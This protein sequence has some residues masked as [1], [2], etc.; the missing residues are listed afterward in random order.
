MDADEYERALQLQPYA[1]VHVGFTESAPSADLL[2]AVK[3]SG[4]AV[5]STV[6]VVDMTLLV[7]QTERM[8]DPWF[9]MLVP[10]NQR[11]TAADAELTNEMLTTVFDDNLPGWVPR[12]LIRLLVPFMSGAQMS[13][14]LASSMSAAKSMY[15]AGIPLVMG[16]D[17]GN[18]P[19]FTSLFHGV[20]SIREMELLEQAGIPR[21]A[22]L[23]AATTR[24]AALLGKSNEI[25]ALMAGMKAD[26]IISNR[27]PT[28]EGMTALRDLAY[29][30]KDGEIRTP[31]EWM[32]EPARRGE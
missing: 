10:R 19:V 4:A 21:E 17:M 30:M 20:G 9:Q 22:V 32:T 29:V 7:Y 28:T 12:T 15:E 23:A 18:W 11:A 24:A 25:G 31:A 2:R 5:I 1:F 27:N 6:A 16:S 14:Q 8:E 13:E 26:L 3:K